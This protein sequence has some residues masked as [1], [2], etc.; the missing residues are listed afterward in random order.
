MITAVIP[1]YREKKNVVELTERLQS[2]FN[3]HDIEYH[4]RYVYQGTDGGSEVLEKFETEDVEVDH[5]PEPLGVGKAYRIGFH[6][7]PS[8]TKYVLTMD[9]DLNHQPEELDEFL[10][11]KGTADIVVGSR[12]INDGDFAQLDSWR[13]IA[14]PFAAKTLSG[15]FD[16]EVNDIS[17]GYRLYDVEVIQS[18]R[19]DLSFDNFEF[20]PEALIRAAQNNYTIT[21]VPINYKPRKHGQ[22]KMNE[23]ETAFG[24]GKLLISMM[25]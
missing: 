25:F 23:I 5:Y 10:D 9:A 18:I 12:F 1:A 14:S 22:S 13:K 24:Y 7:L 2:T 8:E 4:I 19:N 6:D 3:K 15:V 11:M 16:V 17:S 21:E 20:Y